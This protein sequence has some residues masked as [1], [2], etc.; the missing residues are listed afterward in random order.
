VFVAVRGQTALVGE[1][2]QLAAAHPQAECAALLKHRLAAIR[3]EIEVL[4]LPGRSGARSMVVLTRR[5]TR[6]F[7][8]SVNRRSFAIPSRIRRPL[9][10]PRVTSTPS[11]F[12]IA[13][14]TDVSDPPA[15]HSLTSIASALGVHIT[16]ACA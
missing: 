15:S 6:G 11:A 3:R 13:T 5:T 12:V 8:G 10:A 7:L 16:R 4:D 2:A 9:T 1:R 14:A